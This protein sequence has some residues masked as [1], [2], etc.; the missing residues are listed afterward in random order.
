MAFDD[1][2]KTKRK[3]WVRLKLMQCIEDHVAERTALGAT[4]T[5]G[6]DPA[7]LGVLML[8]CILDNIDE[9]NDDGQTDTYVS[10]R[11]TVESQAEEDAWKDDLEK[12]GYT[13]T[14]R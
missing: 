8:D 14:K 9:F 5:L 1:D 3:E 4:P 2:Q 13:V 12:R 7:A 11:Q 6:S 10:A